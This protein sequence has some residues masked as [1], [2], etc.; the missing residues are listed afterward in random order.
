[1]IHVSPPCAE[2]RLRTRRTSSA[3]RTKETAIASTPLF[4]RKFEICGV[5]FR[6][7]RNA[8]R[9]AGQI[10]A[11]VLAKHAAVDDFADYIA[12]DHLVNAKL[13]EA[14]RKQDARALFDILR[15]GLERGANQ[16]CGAW[17]IARRDGK[18]LPVL[19]STGW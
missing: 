13:D 18:R 14:I 19:S 16:G 15:Q 9:N 6:Q 10:D 1:M 3:V 2:T 8:Y 17:D 4:Q 12:A 7:R 11:L 5:L